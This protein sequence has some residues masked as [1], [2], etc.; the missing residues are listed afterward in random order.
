MPTNSYCQRQRITNQLVRYRKPTPKKI[1]K[2]ITTS[3]N[4]TKNTVPVTWNYAHSF[5]LPK[6]KNYYYYLVRY[7]KYKAKETKKTII[8]TKNQ[9]RKTV[10]NSQRSL[11]L[12]LECIPYPH[13]AR[14]IIDWPLL[15][16]II[17]IVKCS[18]GDDKA[19]PVRFFMAEHPQRN[20]IF[21]RSQ[22]VLITESYPPFSKHIALLLACITFLEL[23]RKRIALYIIRRDWNSLTN[24]IILQLFIP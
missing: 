17:Q 9:T 22:A 18:K 3:K 8:T 24:D 1:K 14:L 21:K 4:Q 16:A 5:L 2:T 11:L 23:H 19:K 20:K 10:S 12:V 6:A 7:Q 15:D 13:I